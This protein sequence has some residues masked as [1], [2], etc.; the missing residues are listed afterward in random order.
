MISYTPIYC[1]NTIV[2]ECFNAPDADGGN[3]SW[4]SAFWVCNW[5]SNMTYPRYNQVFPAVQR[6]R[7]EL[8]STWIA[9]QPSVEAKAQELYKMSPDKAQEF[10]NSYSLQCAATMLKDWKK[11]GEYII[12]KYNDMTVKPKK[13]ESLNAQPMGFVYLLSA[14]DFLESYKSL[15]YKETANK[16][17]VPS[18]P[19]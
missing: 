14:R 6:V 8:D 15:P 7:N 17:L 5:V 18:I 4:K 3:F 16:Y 1:Q 19:K 2:P 11:L 9:Q 13:M 12:V 10:L